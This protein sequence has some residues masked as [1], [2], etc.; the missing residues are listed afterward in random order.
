MA[1]EDDATI[2]PQREAVA[3]GIYTCVCGADVRIDDTAATVR[4]CPNCQRRI[5]EGN[6][7]SASMSIGA[8]IIS[9]GNDTDSDLLPVQPG[10]HLDHFSVISLLGAGGMGAV[11]R[12]RDESL[13]RYVALK[14]IR[15]GLENSLQRDRIIQEARA[16]AR[17]SHNHVVHIYFVGMHEDCPFFA[18]ELVNGPTLAEVCREQRLPF[19]EIVRFGLE[20]T[21]ALA[22]SAQL[23][24]IHGDVK[25]SNILLNEQRCVKLSDFGLAGLSQDGDPKRST[26]GP[27]GT[28]NY[29]APEVAGGQVPNAKSDMYSLGVMLYELT[30]G[31]LPHQNSSNSLQENLKHRQTADVVLPMV[32]PND[33]PERW[34]IFLKQLLHRDPDQRF[35]SWESVFAA[36]SNWRCITIQPAG[37]ISRMLAWLLD[38]GC[39]LVGAAITGMMDVIPN[40]LRGENASSNGGPLL[41]LAPLFLTW[42]HLRWGTSAGKKLLHLRITDAFGLL[43]SRRK[44]LLKAFSTYLLNWAAV[45]KSLFTFGLSA[46]AIP[47]S[48]WLS[49]TAAIPLILAIIW[50]GV[51]AFWLLFSSERRTL[52]DRL[53]ALRVSVAAAD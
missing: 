38:M 19:S 49:I 9:C 12:A 30:F 51:N 5:A 28:L 18:M 21:E 44:L 6:L 16:Q 13:Q 23:G 42:L 52:L 15:G 26:T 3:T 20:T 34:G 45:F 48:Q 29:M 32:M 31:E 47:E 53:L 11:F 4:V 22:H 41:F 2:R 33:R 50:L 27:A 7:T 37:R 17:V 39:V 36:L 8:T 1:N 43:P 35:D 10:D 46:A 24:I 14:V 25:P 40:I